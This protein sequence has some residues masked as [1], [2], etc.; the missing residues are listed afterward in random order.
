MITEKMGRL[1]SIIPDYKRS[2][3]V[4]TNALDLTT[5][6]VMN[7]DFLWP[8]ESDLSIGEHETSEIESY[9]T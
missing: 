7:R 9:S 6:L 3:T 1:M 4:L 8:V 2:Q 5:S